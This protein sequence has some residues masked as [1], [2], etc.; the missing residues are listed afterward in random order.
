M[1]LLARPTAALALGLLLSASAWAGE[2]DATKKKDATADKDATASSATAAPA[3]KPSTPAADPATAVATPAGDSNAPS[4]SGSAAPP[5]SSSEHSQVVPVAPITGE[6]ATT[7]TLESGEMLGRHVVAFSTGVNKFS[8]AP[9]NTTILNLDL[10]LAVGITDR[11]S[12][13]A[14]PTASVVEV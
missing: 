14:A 8:R 13:K 4:G 11:I 1:R 2:N 5:A 6:R 7:Y 3:E 10:D 9:G 12:E